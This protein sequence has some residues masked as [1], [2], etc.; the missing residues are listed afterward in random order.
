MRD[1]F[2]MLLYI[3]LAAYGLLILSYLF[4]IFG[5]ADKEDKD[6]K[7]FGYALQATIFVCVMYSIISFGMWLQDVCH[8]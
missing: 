2:V 6:I 7:C 1:L 8:L 4:H 3:V 5:C